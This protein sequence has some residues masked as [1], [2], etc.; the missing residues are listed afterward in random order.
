MDAYMA[1]DTMAYPD[2]G[3]QTFVR[4]S[5]GYDGTGG[6]I[7]TGSD[8]GGFAWSPAHDPETEPTVW[9]MANG[10][11]GGLANGVQYYAADAYAVS[12]TPV[13]VPTDPADY[14][15]YLLTSG[16]FWFTSDIVNTLGDPQ[17]WTLL[18]DTLGAWKDGD[19]CPADDDDGKQFAS[20]R[21]LVEHPF[22]EDWLFVGSGVDGYRGVYLWDTGT[23]TNGG[24][25]FADLPYSP[26][27]PIPSGLAV[28]QVITELLYTDWVM[29]G[30][31]TLVPGDTTLGDGALY[32]C[33][34]GDPASAPTPDCY[35]VADDDDGLTAYDVRDIE[36]DPVVA[37]RWYVADGGH[38][39][40]GT[41]TCDYY[42]NGN[43]TDDETPG[44]SWESTVLAVQV[45]IVAGIPQIE[46]WDTD[47]TTQD[48]ITWEGSTGLP[49]YQTEEACHHN[50]PGP[51]WGDLVP[52]DASEGNAAHTLTTITVDP[53][54]G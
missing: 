15:I 1:F 8:V 38:R 3:P 46:V 2:T 32:L 19:D 20:G 29:V 7:L 13:E 22:D 50:T 16:S 39:Y 24:L 23:Q 5:E 21:L 14:D 41:S 9:N 25:A 33:W 4:V 6:L 11:G 37:G 36:P 35:P 47:T 27:P 34:A 30:Y 54:G 28:N 43:G 40:D 31:R 49:Y 53:D 44:E 48:M 10:G 45:T 26:T 17:E 42:D 51:T 12:H 18:T 52:P